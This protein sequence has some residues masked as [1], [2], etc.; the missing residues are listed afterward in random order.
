METPRMNPHDVPPPIEPGDDRPRR[1]FDHEPLQTIE[2]DD[3]PEY[4]AADITPLETLDEEGHGYALTV[5]IE[6]LHGLGDGHFVEP[7]SWEVDDKLRELV[8]DEALVEE[9]RLRFEPLPT[10]TAHLGG[11]P[12][13]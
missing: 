4:D 3:H 7:D 1:S 9:E 6:G 12:G 13:L 10:Y 5:Y 8:L 2:L 11:D